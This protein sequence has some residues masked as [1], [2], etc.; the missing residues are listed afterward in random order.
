MEAQAIIGRI[1]ERHGAHCSL[2]EFYTSLNL[3]FHEFESESYDELHKDM[4]DSL[5]AQVALFVD[6]C[7]SSY[8]DMPKNI[9]ILDIGCG[10][11]LAT[12][13]LLRTAIGKSIKSIDLVDIS[14]L[15][16]QHASQ[17]AS[18]WG[19]PVTSHLGLLDSLPAGK[20]YEWIITCSVLHHMPDLPAFLQ[21][22]RGV[23]S[24]GGVFLHLQDPNKD[25]L[26]DPDLL[27]RIARGSRRTF[28]NWVYRFA[29]RKL[30]ARL[31]RELSRKQAQDYLS[32]TNRALLQ[33]GLIATPL[34][35]SEIFAITDI[36][37]HDGDGVS[38]SRMKDWMPNYECL[39]QRSYAFFG[40]LWSVLPPSY[41]RIEEDLSR[42]R[43]PN[44][45]EFG[46]VWRLRGGPVA[47]P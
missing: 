2:Q 5:P 18:V 44:G 36:Q 28:P 39:S 29:P 38:F 26:T 24:E 37:A 9:H 47:H 4:W 21:A 42:R 41:R 1:M 11:G 8:P 40:K 23:Q 6:D 25:F 20:R 22:V 15:M 31:F 3:T 35:A 33:K 7:I 13:S 14:P 34:S 16:L 32:R 17:R 43:A 30:A 27:E 12:D 10:T 45:G 46:A 19:L